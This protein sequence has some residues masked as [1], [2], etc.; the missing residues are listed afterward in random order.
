MIISGIKVYLLKKRVIF[1]LPD[2]RIFK[3]SM[4]L[5]FRTI[6]L[7]YILFTFL[8]NPIQ[9]QNNYDIDSLYQCLNQAK[10]EKLRSEILYQ[11]TAAYL[12]KDLKM[13]DSLNQLNALAAEKM[14]NKPLLAKIKYADFKI[15]KLKNDNKNA[16]IHIK[17]SKALFQYLGDSV[18]FAS[19]LVDEGTILV[20]HKEL[21]K[22]LPLL[23]DAKRIFLNYSLKKELS[24]LYSTLGSLY[25]TLG[26]IYHLSEDF[27]T[28]LKYHHLSL[29][30][31][32]ERN[33]DKGISVNY[34]NIGNTYNSQKDYVKAHDY[35]LKAYE[36]KVKIDDKPGMQ[37]CLNNLGVTQMNS[38]NF[39]K[40]IEYHQKAVE[41]ALELKNEYYIAM[42]YINL[43][44][45]Y[46]EDKNYNQA[47]L[48]SKKGL[49]K[50]EIVK[51][52]ILLKEGSRILSESYEKLN[53]FSN[54]LLHYRLYKFYD[55]S[56]TTR[57]NLKEMREINAR[58]EGAQKDIEIKELKLDAIDH[59]LSLQTTRFYTGL[60][61]GLFLLV[62]IF[63]VFLY[64]QSKNDQ[65]IK[66]KLREIND[67]KSA[68]FANLSH[69]FRTPLTLMLGPTEKLIDEVDEKQKP[70][71]QLI[72]RN[73]SRLLAL[74]EQLLEFTRIDSGIQK[75]NLVKGNLILHI[76]ALVKSF[77]MQ[78]RKKGIHLEFSTEISQ[79]SYIF[80][81]DIVEK[82]ISN[83]LSNAVK[84]TQPEGKIELKIS[85]TSLFSG[86]STPTSPMLLIE[87]K[88]NGPGIIPDKQEQIFE[89]F[90]QLNNYSSGIKD[91]YGIGLALAKEL[92]H[93]HKGKIELESKIGH[94]SNFKV[95]L[96]LDKTPYSN[97]ETKNLGDF[98]PYPIIDKNIFDKDK[99]SEKQLYTSESYQKSNSL[100]PKILIV[101][102]NEDMRIFLREI[103]SELFDV[104]EAEDGQEGLK[105]A[106]QSQ[107]L[108]VVTDI[109]MEKM[110]G[111]EFCN[112]L[113]TRPETQHIPVIM[114]TAL[115]SVDDRISGLENGADDYIT[116]PFNSKELLVRCK[117]LISQRAFLK[118][119][120]T[121]ELKL[122]PKSVNITSSDAV[123]I[124][125]L[126]GIIEKYMDNPDFD[127]EVMSNEIGLSRSQL[128]RKITL[129]T[130]QSATNFIRIIRMKRAAQ[131]LDQRVGNI[132]EVMYA[133]G[134][135]NLSY[136]SKCF[137]E[138]Y[139]ITP[140]EYL[141][142]T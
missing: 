95:F 109:M 101:D 14:D 45:D 113:K 73:A 56:L 83:L 94:G 67:I 23:L 20:A 46:S 49:E 75:L 27:E 28:S 122:E 25:N 63:V 97:E 4:A 52:L 114:L 106:L 133:V 108:L 121:S 47:I 87:V 2:Y 15:C 58:F 8:P 115:T 89:R 136:F 43:G 80:D 37:K 57:N 76:S 118:D 38:G 33:F 111:I 84:Y 90:Y 131:L 138:V 60:F 68:F 7:V 92:V 117:N 99:Q 132:S 39:K 13:A 120:F 66:T 19:C 50:A 110:D 128:H 74:D 54:A 24:L 93:L 103:M 135:N 22:A 100:Q 55:D 104:V 85:E 98:K 69:E 36:I 71:L 65:K 30:I 18:N 44:Y 70:L 129:L 42:A 140:S 72:H 134:L 86:Q 78:A 141:S 32:Q 124:Q 91:G 112:Q 119:L 64:R 116:K 107:P 6:V 41:L 88:D 48:F 5:S 137:K 123:F 12:N 51:D 35:Y 17:E 29:E 102:D 3:G 81:S 10:D 105:K 9:A 61:V 11:I 16:L 40:A 130:N 79:N 26:N 127:V 142:K 77:E 21:Q 82:V 34:L 59:E 62:T 1:L 139:Q 126:I 125:K 53:N 31:N 96:P